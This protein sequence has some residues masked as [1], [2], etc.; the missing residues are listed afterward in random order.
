MPVERVSFETCL[1]EVVKKIIKSK[2]GRS[3]MAEIDRAIL[4]ELRK[5]G[6]MPSV[7]L[8]KMAGGIERTVRIHVRRMEEVS[9]HA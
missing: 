7:E 9:D 5:N 1:N 4:V 6:H 8:A 2:S 3:I